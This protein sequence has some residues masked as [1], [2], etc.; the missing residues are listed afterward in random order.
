MADTKTF[1]GELLMTPGYAENRWQEVL[2]LYGDPNNPDP[3]LISK[4][5]LQAGS[6]PGYNNLCDMDRLLQTASHIAAALDY[7]GHSVPAIAL[8]VKHGNACG[9][10]IHDD[11]EIATQQMVDGDPIAIFGGSTMFNFGVTEQVADE[12]IHHGMEKG[13]R[14]I[15]T[16][17]APGMDEG[18]PEHIARKDGK[19]RIM[20]N[21]ALQKIGAK[22][23]DTAKRFRFMRGGEALIQSNYTFIPDF[24]ADERLQQGEALNATLER[25]LLLAWAIGSTS[26]SNTITLVKNGMLIGNGVG[27][28]DRVSAARL[29]VE[30]ARQSGHDTEGAVAYSDSFFPFTDGP[31][32]LV[33]AGVQAIFTSSGSRN[34]D[35]VFET[36]ENGGVRV[37]SLPDAEMRG[38]FVH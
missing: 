15:D 28:Q 35:E 24:R 9:A 38:F 27:Q 6:V 25:Y 8:G 17:Y 12:L 13:R 19:W 2:G 26:N 18:V 36:F 16:V 7:N 34:D 10:S 5:E 20:T 3:L 1:G 29:A 33:D 30:K 22:S 14:L 32:V 11:P 4:F 21:A 23:L 37:V 31:Q